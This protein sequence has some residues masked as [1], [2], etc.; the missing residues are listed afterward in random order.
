MPFVWDIY[1]GR[2]HHAARTLTRA[3]RGRTAAC[4]IDC[5]DHGSRNVNDLEDNGLVTAGD[6]AVLA[7]PAHGPRQHR[8]LDVGAEAHQILNVV[9]VIHPHDVLLD[10]RS[11]VEIL[12]YIVGGRAE[13]L[14][15]RSFA[16]RYGE[17]R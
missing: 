10:N 12:G 6:D 13:S 9:A 16:R 8:T 4:D 7:V 5:V 17:R 3:R 2:R 14:T 11:L 1:Q 15:P